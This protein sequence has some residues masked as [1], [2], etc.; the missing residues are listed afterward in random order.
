MIE[1]NTK[2]PNYQTHPSNS[3]ELDSSKSKNEINVSQELKAIADLIKNT[4]PID[5]RDSGSYYSLFYEN[6]QFKI[7]RITSKN[8]NTNYAIQQKLSRQKIDRLLLSAKLSDVCE[9]GIIDSFL[10]AQRILRGDTSKLVDTYLTL[11]EDSI[12]KA[13]TLAIKSLFSQIQECFDAQQYLDAKRNLPHHPLCRDEKQ[14]LRNKN[15]A[16][17]LNKAVQLREQVLEQFKDL[18]LPTIG[19]KSRLNKINIG[20]IKNPFSIICGF[21][22]FNQS[23]RALE[24]LAENQNPWPL[25]ESD[26]QVYF[27][28]LVNEFLPYENLD[29]VPQVFIEAFSKCSYIDLYA[30]EQLNL[31]KNSSSELSKLIEV[32][33]ALQFI[34]VQK[35]SRPFLDS[36]FVKLLDR[37][38]KT[39]QVLELQDSKIADSHLIT[40]KQFPCLKKIVLEG[41]AID[42]SCFSSQIFTNVQELSLSKCKDLKEE[43]CCLI[44]SK[45]LKKLSLASTNINGSC[46]SAKVFAHLYELNLSYCFLLLDKHLIHLSSTGLILIHLSKTLINGSCF[47]GNAFVS[48]QTLEMDQCSN[49]QDSNLKELSSNSLKY[50]SAMY[51]PINGSCFN[52]KAF[53]SLEELY[54]DAC[55][56]LEDRHLQN[57]P[58]ANLQRIEASSTNLTGVF[59]KG[60]AFKNLVTA[61]LDSCPNISDE[62]LKNSFTKN[63][64]SLSLFNSAIDGSCLKEETFAKLEYLGL[65]DCE[66][67][68]D[69]H[70][71]AMSPKA[72]KELDLTST[73]IDGSCFQSPPFKTLITLR[74]GECENL[75]EDNLKNVQDFTKVIREGSSN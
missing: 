60:E 36:Y 48:V 15:Y 10:D 51:T 29:E 20:L 66:N 49:V 52:G 12:K 64:K 57:I 6:K 39:V 22:G 69:I 43:N 14:I 8:I 67:I 32:P 17:K 24:A 23:Q 44:S 56:R 28:S 37:N 53:L 62:N 65:G 61:I 70:I 59:L 25:F 1:S 75:V 19:H 50:L 46:L 7:V 9:K 13:D 4:Q 55:N 33:K 58:F 71:T 47:R 11:V 34:D 73:S 27:D 74:I 31:F 45:N 3:L 21:L 30:I 54:L 63:L 35:A 38:H 41:T 42:G 18:S 16:E 72:L 5:P 40:E 68:S 2:T 26:P